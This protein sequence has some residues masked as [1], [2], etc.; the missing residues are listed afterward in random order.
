[1]PIPNVLAG[2]AVDNLVAAR[3][4]YARLL[5]RDGTSP[6]PEVVEWNFPTGGGLQVFEDRLRAGSSSVTLVVDDLDAE[7]RRIQALGVEIGSRTSSD[8]VRTFTVHDPSENQVI[9]AQARDPSLLR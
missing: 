2:V 7:Q 5:E 1:M 6:M 8:A 9:L 3:A 4:W